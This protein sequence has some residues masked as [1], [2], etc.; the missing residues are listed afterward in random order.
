[1]SESHGTTSFDDDGGDHTTASLTQSLNSRKG[2]TL[3]RSAE[4][5]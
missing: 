1:M 4:H 2:E 5:E 3:R